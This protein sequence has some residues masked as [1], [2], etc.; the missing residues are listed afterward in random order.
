MRNRLEQPLKYVADCLRCLVF[1]AEHSFLIIRKFTLLLLLLGLLF[2]VIYA[3]CEH[4]ICDQ[5]GLVQFPIARV[6]GDPKCLVAPML[7]E[8]LG[9]FGGVQELIPI[10]VQVEVDHGRL[11]K[12]ALLRPNQQIG[13]FLDLGLRPL[14][15]IKQLLQLVNIILFLGFG[16]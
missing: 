16:Q 10:G 1:P 13:V 11:H 6:V 8:V 15:A 9:H 14:E 12:F 4:I 7:T 2:A 5:F 3:H